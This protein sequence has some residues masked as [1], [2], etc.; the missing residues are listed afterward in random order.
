[1][2]SL[3][4]H[5][6]SFTDPTNYAWNVGNSSE[7]CYTP[8]QVRRFLSQS[9]FLLNSKNLPARHR[10]GDVFRVGFNVP[11]IGNVRMG[12]GGFQEVHGNSQIR[13]LSQKCVRWLLRISHYVSQVGLI[14]NALLHWSLLGV[15]NELFPNSEGDLSRCHH[16]LTYYLE[17][18][19]TNKDE[20]LIAFANRYLGEYHLNNVRKD[21]FRS[22]KSHHKPKTKVVCEHFSGARS[23]A[24]GSV[25]FSCFK[26][27]YL[28]F[29]VIPG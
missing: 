3:K 28:H 23:S 8:S 1:M 18:A 10:N 2:E 22:L 5:C 24:R 17:T 14:N 12:K 4:R 29:R 26:L 27:F 6:H 15:G 11:G 13:K 25:D 9:S 20:N 19:E 7:K 16:S 21:Y